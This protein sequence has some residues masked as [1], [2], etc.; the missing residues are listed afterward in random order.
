MKD[1]VLMLPLIHVYGFTYEKEKEGALDYFCERIANAMQYPDFRKEDILS[2][3]NIRDVSGTSHMYS[4]TF[5]LP[6]EVA[7]ST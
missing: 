5:R 2:F 3:H 1:G 7:M 6:L 4:T